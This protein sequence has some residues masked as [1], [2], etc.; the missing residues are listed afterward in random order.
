MATGDYVML[1][2]HDALVAVDALYEMVSVLNEDSSTDIIYTDE[3][4]VNSDT[5]MYFS[6]NFKP[7]FN[8]E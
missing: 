1:C 2:D 7:D 8:F 6:P 3:D 4:K 5:T